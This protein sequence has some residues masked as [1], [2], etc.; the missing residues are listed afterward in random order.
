VSAELENGK[1]EPLDWVPRGTRTP[2]G[3]TAAHTEADPVASRPGPGPSS[4]AGSPHKV[5]ETA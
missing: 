2:A 1:G 3:S 5:K 4:A